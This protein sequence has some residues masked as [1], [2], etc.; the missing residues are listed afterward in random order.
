M[1]EKSSLAKNANLLRQ[2]SCRT[3]PSIEQ[4]KV[5]LRKVDYDVRAVKLSA[6]CGKCVKSL[7]QSKSKKIV[8]RICVQLRSVIKI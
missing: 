1:W 2:K 8:V 7:R 5:L 6:N 4:I 3:H